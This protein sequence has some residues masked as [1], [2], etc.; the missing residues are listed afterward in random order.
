MY[1]IKAMPRVSMLSRLLRGDM[2]R[3]CTFVHVD[4]RLV[5]RCAFF[6]IVTGPASIP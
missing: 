1:Y 4:Q 3:G 2:S 6:I 5:V